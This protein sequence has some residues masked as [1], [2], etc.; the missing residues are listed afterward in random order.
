M[1]FEK[2]Y[3]LVYDH[4]WVLVEKLYTFV[5][6]FTPLPILDETLDTIYGLYLMSTV[7]LGAYSQLAVRPAF[8][9][10]PI[11]SLRPSSG[12]IGRSIKGRPPGSSFEFELSLSNSNCPKQASKGR[13][14]SYASYKFFTA[15]ERDYI[16]GRPPGSSFELEMS[17]TSFP[18]PLIVVRFL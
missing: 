11:N 18:R 2:L 16:K 9:T 10:L 12:I 4:L 5:D 17:K 7:F 6:T 3:N 8:R 14:S 13:S 15:V 1:L